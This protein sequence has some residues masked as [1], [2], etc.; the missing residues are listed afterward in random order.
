MKADDM[1]RDPVVD[2]I[3]APQLIRKQVAQNIR[4]GRVLRRLLK[5]AEFAAKELSPQ[6][7][8]GEV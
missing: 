7:H 8:D 1:R 6:Q 3:P 5:V 2:R 4:E